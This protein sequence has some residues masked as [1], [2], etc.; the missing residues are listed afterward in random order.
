VKKKQ[1]QQASLVNLSS[2][3]NI[4]YVTNAVARR[5]KKQKQTKQKKLATRGQ[6]K[7]KGKLQKK[8]KTKT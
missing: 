7:K 8:Q 1:R 3:K 4:C 6:S 2:K 5:Q